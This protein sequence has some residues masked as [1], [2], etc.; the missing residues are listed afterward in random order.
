MLWLRDRLLG[1]VFISVTRLWCHVKKDTIL[2]LCS[3]HM[4]RRES[5][6][7]FN[8]KYGYDVYVSY[9]TSLD[10]TNSHKKR[11][12]WSH[13]APLSCVPH[14][15]TWWAIETFAECC[16]HTTCITKFVRKYRSRLTC[17][18]CLSRFSVKIAC[19]A[20]EQ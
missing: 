2:F 8:F 9:S 10:L 19:L 6:Q 11:F 5:Q 18:Q 17:T 13:L 3:F 1:Y 15:V 4:L 12:S 20:L 14:I 7:I 16:W